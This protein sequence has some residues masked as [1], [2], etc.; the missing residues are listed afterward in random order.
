MNTIGGSDAASCM[1]CNPFQSRAELYM[2]LLG[3]ETEEGEKEAFG[4]WYGKRMEPV[5][6]E[7]YERVT[8]R[9]PIDVP[10]PPPGADLKKRHRIY[11]SSMRY[12][13]AHGHPD[14]M[15]ADRGVEYK[16]A[17]PAFFREWGLAPNQVPVAYYCQCQHYMAITG[18]DRWD[19][20]INIGTFFDVHELLRDDTFIETL[21]AKE[22]AAWDEAVGLGELH[23]RDPN[24]FAIRMDTL[25]RGD[26]ELRRRIAVT[27][28]P[29]ASDSLVDCP[30]EHELLMRDVFKRYALRQEAERLFGES[31]ALAR[32]AV[33]ARAGFKCAGGMIL[34]QNRGNARALLV[35]PAG[36]LKEPAKE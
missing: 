8:G 19:L 10:P 32:L 2:K 22:K 23:K 3:L 17:H 15:C 34:W 18:M 4:L 31:A 27:A 21:M 14:D 7:C 35:R 28:W 26:E 11:A 25:A 30:P 36:G 1:A 33:G 12:A 24:A 6:R 29:R 20:C 9:K 13:W 5:L 16:T